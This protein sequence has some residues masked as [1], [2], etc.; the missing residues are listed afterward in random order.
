MRGAAIRREIP[1]SRHIPYAAHVAP[2]VIV[3]N[4][5][6]YLQ[7]FRLSGAS[8]ESADDEDLN[9]WHERLNVTWRNI[10]SPNVA[11]WTHVVRR[12]ACATAVEGSANGF[13]DRLAVKYQQRLSGETLMVNELYAT[14][15][16][17]PV[18]GAATGLASKLLSRR[19][20][21]TRDVDLADALDACEKL[22]QTIFASL[23]RYEPE[24]LRV[25]SRAGRDF[26]RL[27]EF[28]AFLI[29]GEWQPVPLPRAPLSEVLATTRPIFGTE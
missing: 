7:T 11:L 18:A 25:Y 12:R 5:G 10:A 1:A 26:S 15:L 19:A 24:T 20:R 4:Q 8:F 6:G 27:L 21:P 13:A 17:R 29:N 3:T 14:V 16:Y 23:A 9:N 28:F 2:E 22:G